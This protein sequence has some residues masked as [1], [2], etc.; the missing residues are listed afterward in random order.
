[1]ESIEHVLPVGTDAE[2]VLT[3][4]GGAGYL[5]DLAPLAA[6]GV[7]VLSRSAATVDPDSVGGA[8]RLTLVLRA[9]APTTVEVAQRRPWLPMDDEGAV[10]GRASL[11]FA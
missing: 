5:W 2:V 11:V 4:N 6:A 8:A 7:A 1:M 9:E 10:C 3:E